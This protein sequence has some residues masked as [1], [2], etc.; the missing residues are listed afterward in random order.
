M[1]YE[2]I[3]GIMGG[4]YALHDGEK[5]SIALAIREHYMPRRAGEPVPESALGAILGLADRIDTIAGCFGIGQVPRITSYNVC[6]TKLLRVDNEISR[7]AQEGRNILRVE[8]LTKRIGACLEK[9][10]AIHWFSV[11]VHNFGD[12]CSTFATVESC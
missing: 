6:Y 3:T 12:E 7:L 1:L 4:A 9:I 11:T 5:E 2:V 8:P 10:D